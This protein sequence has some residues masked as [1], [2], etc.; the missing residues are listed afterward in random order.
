MGY[1]RSAVEKIWEIKVDTHEIIYPDKYVN[2]C[3]NQEIRGQRPVQNHGVIHTLVVSKQAKEH[4]S[5][6]DRSQHNHRVHK[7]SN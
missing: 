2:D 4:E 3:K 5:W 6:D 7:W 1:K